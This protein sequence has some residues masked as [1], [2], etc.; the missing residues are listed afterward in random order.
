MLAMYVLVLL[1]NP[2]NSFPPCSSRR[3]WW[4]VL[5]AVPFDFIAVA[6]LGTAGMLNADTGTMMAAEGGWGVDRTL[7]LC[8]LLRL[9]HLVWVL[10]LW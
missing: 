2:Y 8:S 3:F 1:P 5:G 10:Y 6:A 9:L 4:D 7:A